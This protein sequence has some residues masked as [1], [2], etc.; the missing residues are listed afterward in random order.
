MDTPLTEL[1]QFLFS[2]ALSS[3]QYT[4]VIASLVGG[5]VLLC[6]AG[7]YSVCNSRR[8]LQAV[9]QKVEGSW[10]AEEVAKMPGSASP[11]TE[12]LFQSL[13]FLGRLTQPRRAEDLSRIRK[14]LLQAGYRSADAPMVFLG[15]KLFLTVLLPGFY[16]FLRP[17]SLSTLPYTYT[18]FFLLF[19]ALV[20]FYAPDMCLRMRVHRRSRQIFE[21]LPNA[22]DL[23]VVCVEAGLGLDAAIQRVGQEMQRTYKVL[24]EELALVDFGLRAGQTR[25]VALKNLSLR[26]DLEEVKSFVAVLIQTDRFGTSVAQAL[27]VHADVMRL[28]RRQ[29]AEELA[30]KIPVKLLFPLI[31]F[32][33]PSLF[34]V[35]VGPAAIQIFRHLLPLMTRS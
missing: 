17:P 23:L 6:A 8:A 3:S 12:G 19:T 10:E 29:K 14:L 7:F 21:G 25:Q 5:T 24:H 28:K 33:L 16:V 4:L 18:M 20:G 31:F 34:V 27:R 30:M 2:L 26:I 22:L 9:R 15:I 1:R 35:M 13:T 11:V 32:I